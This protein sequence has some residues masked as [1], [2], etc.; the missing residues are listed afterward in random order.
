MKSLKTSAAVLLSGGM[1]SVLALLWAKAKYD[2]VYAIS[3]EYEQGFQTEFVSAQK[4]AA[5]VD[6]TWVPEECKLPAMLPFSNSSNNKIGYIPGLYLLM[7]VFGSR[8]CN[9]EEPKVLN[10]VYGGSASQKA[11]MRHRAI[12]YQTDALQAV[13][14][15][16]F[17][18]WIPNLYKTKADVVKTAIETDGAMDCIAL[19]HTCALGVWPPCEKCDKCIERAAA[20][21]KVGIK[22]PIAKRGQVWQKMTKS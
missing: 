16:N 22:D 9:T 20:F 11:D 4:I 2:E 10:L 13:F 1:D 19:S 5:L 6:V 21:K 7:L 15:M 18:I 8:W 12:S 14:G 17:N 3:Y